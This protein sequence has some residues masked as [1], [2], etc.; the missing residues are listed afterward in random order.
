VAGKEVTPFVLKRVNEL[1]K[2]ASLKAN[3]AL[4]GDFYLT[5]GMLARV[6]L[7]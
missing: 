5:L 3:I 7:R 2:G 1:T 4:V 6:V